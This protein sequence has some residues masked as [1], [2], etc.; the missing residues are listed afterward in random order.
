[1]GRI[2]TSVRIDNPSE[3]DAS[4]RCDARVDTG[5]SHMVLPSAWRDRL[6][7]LVEIGSVEVEIAAQDVVEA[8]VC[9]PVRIQVQGF[10]PIFSEFFFID[11]NP[12]DGANER[13]VGYIVLEQPK[14]RLTWLDIDWS[15]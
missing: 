14:R 6:G 12:G 4:I 3:M 13:L 1:M 11:M 7:N 9:G 15:M 2:R 5:A 8:T 10:R